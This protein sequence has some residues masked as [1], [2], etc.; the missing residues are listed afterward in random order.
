MNALYTVVL[1]FSVLGA[2]DYVIGNKLG[3]GKEF[4]RAFELLGVMALSM[5]GM[6]VLS[7][8]LAEWLA[9][10]F[11]FVHKAFG[12]DPSILPATLFAND[13]GIFVNSA[14]A[15]SA[16]C[17]FAGHLAF[18]VA[19]DASYLVPMLVG[20]LTAGVLALFLAFLLY[21]KM[22]RLSPKNDGASKAPI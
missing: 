21:V 19:F 22:A 2:V 7:P 4:A 12:L 20:K 13:K 14:F 1:I 16:A 9:P 11:N 15:V 5:I 18:T 10:V 3:V 8:L 6:L 17:S